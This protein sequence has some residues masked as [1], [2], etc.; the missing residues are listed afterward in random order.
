MMMASA[1]CLLLSSAA[2]PLAASAVK[3]DE[4]GWMAA[5]MRSEGMLPEDGPGADPENDPQPWTCRNP[6]PDGSCVHSDPTKAQWE[7]A[8]KAIPQGKP[9]KD[10]PNIVFSLTVSRLA[11]PPLSLRFHIYC[12]SA[13]HSHL[14]H[15]S[16]TTKMSRSAAGIR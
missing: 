2:L 6:Q 5:E 9:C 13:T 15:P 7:F 14:R 10:C 16:R 11:R 8:Q 4:Y 3:K 1:L 12:S